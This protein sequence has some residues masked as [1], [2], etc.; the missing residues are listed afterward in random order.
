MGFG[1]AWAFQDVG[2]TA[3]FLRSVKERLKDV[4]IQ[5]IQSNIRESFELYMYLEINPNFQVPNYLKSTL[6]LGKKRMFTLLHLF[7]L[8]IKSN[9]VKINVVDDVTCEN[10]HLLT[11]ENAFHVV[12]EFPKYYLVR[13]HWLPLYNPTNMIDYLNVRNENVIKTL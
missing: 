2:N 9:Y 6:P 13:H 12:F 1:Y 5:M 7:S 8:P 4:S 11:E 10:C 3:I